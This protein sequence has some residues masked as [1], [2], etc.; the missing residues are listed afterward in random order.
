M[1]L[2]FLLGTTYTDEKSFK[3]NEWQGTSRL[4]KQFTHQLIHN[5]QSSNPQN[6]VQ[7]ST[8]HGLQNYKEVKIV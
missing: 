3:S 8:T 2:C 6:T 1:S 7:I 5:P 4:N